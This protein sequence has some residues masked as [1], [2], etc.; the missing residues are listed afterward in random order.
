MT[1]AAWK[2]DGEKVGQDIS[3]DKLPVPSTGCYRPGGGWDGQEISELVNLV[4]D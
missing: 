1:D 4:V 2:E 3:T